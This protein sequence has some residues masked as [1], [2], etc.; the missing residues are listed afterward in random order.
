MS[1]NKSHRNIGLEGSG[2]DKALKPKEPI[3]PRP[4]RKVPT[5]QELKSPYLS[6]SMDR[7]TYTYRYS[8]EV[9]SLHF[10]KNKGEIFHRGHNLHNIGVTGTIAEQLLNFQKVIEQSKYRKSFLK[11]YIAAIEKLL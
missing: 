11:E 8:N 2:K 10:D 4:P 6:A 5:A 7:L 3:H 9:M 1:I